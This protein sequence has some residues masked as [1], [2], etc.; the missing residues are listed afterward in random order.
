MTMNGSEV[1]RF[2]NTG[3]AAM[4]LVER[5]IGRLRTTLDIQKELVDQQRPLVEEAAGA[6]T[7]REL[8]RV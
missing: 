8:Q 5:L 3:E 1:F 7:D 6:C 4:L 2:D